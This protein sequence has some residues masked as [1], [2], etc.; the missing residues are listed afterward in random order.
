MTFLTSPSFIFQP[1]CSIQLIFCLRSAKIKVAL[2]LPESC[3]INNLKQTRIYNALFKLVLKSW[4]IT[5][6]H[7]FRF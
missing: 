5:G 2:L 3:E 4:I 1:V 7:I 6:Y